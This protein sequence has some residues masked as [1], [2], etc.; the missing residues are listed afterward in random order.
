MRKNLLC[1]IAGFLAIL[2]LLLVG[3]KAEDGDTKGGKQTIPPET[4]FTVHF[5]RQVARKMTDDGWVYTFVCNSA[6]D[7]DNS[8]I[9]RYQFFAMNI[10]FKYGENSIQ[11]V[12]NTLDNGEVV[13]NTYVQPVQFWGAAT[14]AQLRDRQIIDS[15]IKDYSR[16][17]EELLAVNRDDYT[18]E[19]IDKNIFF[20]LMQQALTSPPQKEGTRLSYWEKPTWAFLMEP[21]YLSGYK[22]QVAFMQETGCVDELYIDVLY[23]TE[24][25][26]TDYMQLSV[27]VEEG[28]ATQEQ[29]ELFTEIQ[30]I[31]AMIKEEELFIAGA[32]SYK[33]KVYGDVKL[34]RLYTFLMDIHE[35]KFDRYDD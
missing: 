7:G 32:D 14:Q 16:Q 25:G 13:T 8:D 6:K 26:L 18:L 3:C 27:L 33:D 9:I 11:V 12:Q 15:I 22:F 19:T 17:P 5:S 31:T 23:P 29:Y 10:R 34:S 20:D 2:S 24:T 21:D 28:K 30:R 35:N 4:D 1:K